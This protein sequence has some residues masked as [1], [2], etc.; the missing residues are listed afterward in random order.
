MCSILEQ[1]IFSD[2]VYQSL[3][4][5]AHAHGRKRPDTARE[6]DTTVPAASELS[7]GE[8]HRQ[9]IEMLW[10]PKFKNPAP[11]KNDQSRGANGTTR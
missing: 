4:E 1:N 8:L 11:N 7:D 6:A 5:S 2:V 9:Q 3:S 10:C